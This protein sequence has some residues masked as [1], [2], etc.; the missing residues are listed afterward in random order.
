MG[1][2]AMG[3]ESAYIAVGVVVPDHYG[4]FVND[5]PFHPL[6]RVVSIQQNVRGNRCD[7]AQYRD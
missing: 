7:V 1:I 5:A 4:I 6:N 2:E 3:G